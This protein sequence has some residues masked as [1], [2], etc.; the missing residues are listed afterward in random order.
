MHK[1]VCAPG[2]A[3]LCGRG[4]SA[5]AGACCCRCPPS[6]CAWRASRPT[7]PWAALPCATCGRP[8]PSAS[9][10][11]SRRRTPPARCVFLV[12]LPN[13][14]R[15]EGFACLPAASPTC[16][17]PGRV[18]EFLYRTN[19]TGL[20]EVLVSLLPAT[21]YYAGHAGKKPV[22]CGDEHIGVHPLPPSEIVYRYRR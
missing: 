2:M 15:H 17:D 10:R 20:E 9:S 18:W 12:L 19:L 3:T 11:P 6:P 22:V 1:V 13:L 16:P 8:S 7:R 14:G 4:G 5:A 21:C